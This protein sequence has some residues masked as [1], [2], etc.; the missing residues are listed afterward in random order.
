MCDCLC[1]LVCVCEHQSACLCVCYKSLRADVI[2][3]Q[4]CP[5]ETCRIHILDFMLCEK[6]L[7]ENI[8]DMERQFNLWSKPICVGVSVPGI[9]LCSLTL[10]ETI[11]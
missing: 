1:A 5:L 3:M 7:G 10:I 4:R 2:V 8:K 11:C 6:A 9:V